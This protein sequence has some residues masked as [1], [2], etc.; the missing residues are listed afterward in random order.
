METFGSNYAKAVDDLALKIFIPSL[1]CSLWVELGPIIEK[2]IGLNLIVTYTLIAI[3]GFLLYH[4]LELLLLLIC[5]FKIFQKFD[6]GFALGVFLMPL[7]LAGFFPEQFKGLDIPYSQVTGV[8]I[9]AW[10]F[11]LVRGKKHYGFF[12]TNQK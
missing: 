1:I 12:G 6:F 8:S 3:A 2:T 10:S 9:L 5:S 11:I 4:I 7:G